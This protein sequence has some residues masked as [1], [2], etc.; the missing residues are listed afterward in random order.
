M[1]IL[2]VVCGKMCGK[3]C[4]KIEKLLDQNKIWYGTRYG[5]CDY[6]SGDKNT[7]KCGKICGKMCGKI[8]KLSD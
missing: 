4:G 3:M 6:D 5:P 8:E 1:A 7:K 2:V